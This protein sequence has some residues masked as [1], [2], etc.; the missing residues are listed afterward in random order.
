MNFSRTRSKYDVSIPLPPAPGKE[1]AGKMGSMYFGDTEVSEEF[2]DCLE[3]IPRIIPTITTLKADWNIIH[4]VMANIS[5]Q[6]R[7]NIFSF[8]V[9]DYEQSKHN[10]GK[11]TVVEDNE[12]RGLIYTF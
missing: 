7:S 10:S 1:S 9:S 8:I 6:I 11:G 2:P 5:D 4:M 12:R 3:R